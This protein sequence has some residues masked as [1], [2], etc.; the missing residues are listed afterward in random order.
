[1]ILFRTFLLCFFFSTGIADAAEDPL[2]GFFK[3]EMKDHS[4]LESISFIESGKN[5]IKALR[6]KQE[7]PQFR[8][9]K[10]LL[11][12]YRQLQESM[13][14]WPSLKTFVNPIKPLESH[15]EIPKI[16]KILLFWG[17]LKNEGESDL[18]SL[19]YDQQLQDAVKRFQSRHYLENDGVI[20][21]K[22]Y[23]NLNLSIADRIKKIKLN[24]DR[25]RHLISD[26]IGKYIL[27]N[28]A[29]YHLYAMHDAEV[30]LTIPVI[31]GKPTR[32]TPLFMAPLN[33]VVM[34]PGWGVPLS[35]L[36]KDKIKKIRQDPEYLEK[37]G[38]VLSDDEGHSIASNHVDWDH[39]LSH[40]HFP[41]HLRQNPG[42]KNALGP[43]KFNIINPYAIYL[44]GT[45]DL[46]LFD[47][48]SRSLSSGC[49][50]LKHPIDLAVWTLQGTQYNTLEKIQHL[51][52]HKKTQSVPLGVP[53]AVHFSYITVWVDDNG[54]A[55]FSDDPYKMDKRA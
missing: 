9:I 32:K 39:V 36:L 8:K 41:Y 42:K 51:I 3:D 27:V 33:N 52:D 10:T 44:H 47:K 12:D 20:G 2:G 29:N 53:I 31:V 22:T 30:Q 17:D 26:L 46:K 25:W 19:I 45:P 15:A 6:G 55:T 13:P 18:S 23:A 40:H 50:R 35:I 28:I 24:I 11:D 5:F 1:M 16:R 43:I 4:I 48:A 14:E 54:I 21:G 38:Y 7:H 37:G 49:I 34:N